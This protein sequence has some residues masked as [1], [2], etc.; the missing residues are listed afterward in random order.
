MTVKVK[1][2]QWEMIKPECLPWSKIAWFSVSC[3]TPT[4][5][6]LER[7]LKTPVSPVFVFLSK[8]SPAPL[9]LSSTRMASFISSMASFISS[10][11]S[12][13]LSICTSHADDIP[14]NRGSPTPSN[15]I[16]KIPKKKNKSPWSS[17][18]KGVYTYASRQLKPYERNHP[19]HDMELVAVIF[20]LKIWR[21]YL[22]GETS[23][24]YT[25]HKSLKYFLSQ[26]EL[27]M[28]QRKQL[29]LL[30]NYK[31]YILYH[32]SKANVV[33][34]ALNKKPSE[35][36]VVLRVKLPF[37]LFEFNKLSIQFEV[38][39]FGVLFTYLKV[40][41]NLFERIKSLQRDVSQV[42]RGTKSNFVLSGDEILR[43]RTR[44][45]VPQVGNLMKELLKE[46]H[47]YKFAIHLGKTKMYQ[48]LRQLCRW[49]SLKRD[50]T[51]FVAQSLVCQQVKAEHQRPSSK[52]QPLLIPKWK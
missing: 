8:S 29:E 31:C 25:N 48:D 40:Q 39:Q 47:S 9:L 30:K 11:A 7:T 43:F 15:N 41:P 50:V 4:S 10:M 2:L 52:L 22:Y 20:A 27:N 5:T 16:M 23:E 42:K 28:R 45:Y 21:H 36:L 3:K 46:A 18:P 44:L 13:L 19:T 12:L 38:S 26:K 14:S 34:N 17:P 51:Q 49:P 6:L 37:M 1:N 24:I 33:A 35:S 32:L